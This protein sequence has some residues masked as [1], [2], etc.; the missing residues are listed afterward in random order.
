MNRQEGL[1]DNNSKFYY[2]PYLRPGRLTYVIDQN[3]LQGVV[4][5]GPNAQNVWNIGADWARHYIM[6]RD[7]LRQVLL[8]LPKAWAGLSQGRYSWREFLVATRRL[9]NILEKLRRP[10]REI[11]AYVTN[12]TW[13]EKEDG[14]ER[15]LR[16][17]LQRRGMPASLQDWVG[18]QME[19]GPVPPRFHD[20]EEAL[21]WDGNARNPMDKVTRYATALDYAADV[22]VQLTPQFIRNQIPFPTFAMQLGLANQNGGRP[23]PAMNMMWMIDQTLDLLQDVW[24]YQRQGN[25]PALPPPALVPVRRAR[26]DDDEED[27]EGDGDDE[28]HGGAS[29]RRRP[30][31]VS[32]GDTA[33][34]FPEHVM[35]LR[36]LIDA[37]RILKTHGYRGEWP[38]FEEEEALEPYADEYDEEAEENYEEVPLQED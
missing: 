31:Q 38:T 26:Q 1:R 19:Q 14:Y 3:A 13:N 29:G 28:Y 33:V 34:P 15:F 22:L 5:A 21:H 32:G 10:I 36:L 17:A 27:E 37:I 23:G 25:A 4:P 11:F 20:A 12:N 7:V 18:L 2:S 30:R 24:T 16:L 9:A 35:E 6:A 8:Q